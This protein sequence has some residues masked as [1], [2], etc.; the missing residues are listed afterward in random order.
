M[1]GSAGSGT[2]M[3]GVR[4]AVDIAAPG[5]DLTLAEYDGPTGGNAFGG[6]SSLTDNLYRGG[7][8]GTSFSAPIV[9]GAAM[10]PT[11]GLPEPLGNKTF[12]PV[13]EEANRLGCCL[14]VHGGCHDRWG[15]DHFN[16]YVP[17]HAL[18]HP[19]GASGALLVVRLF[20]SL[21]RRG[22]GRSGIA[23]CAVGGGQGIAVLVEAVA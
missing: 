4:A 11:N 12:W 2:L 6:P 16:M 15:L 13:Y 17:V 20:S 8:N 23:T 5:Q 3:T 10:L 7:L 1:I 21:V 9:S 19:W 18:G 14:A 22:R